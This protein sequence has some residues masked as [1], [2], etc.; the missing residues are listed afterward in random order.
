M[1]RGV[2]VENRKP[3]PPPQSLVQ[4]GFL[5]SYVG[6]QSVGLA[7]V[8]RSCW[9]GEPL[10]SIS[11]LAKTRSGHLSSLG[12]HLTRLEVNTYCF[13]GKESPHEN[14]LQKFRVNL[15]CRRYSGC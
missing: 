1:L 4:R 14:P 8:H 12:S 2:A 13:S 15:A 7:Y 9:L 11:P 3:K 10:F 5:D 6:L